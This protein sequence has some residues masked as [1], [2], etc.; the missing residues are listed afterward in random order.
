MKGVMQNEE[1]TFIGNRWNSMIRLMLALLLGAVGIWA[2]VL[3][4]LFLGV[5]FLIAASLAA[6]G[7]LTVLVSPRSRYLRL[8]AT[9]FEVGF[10]HAKD[11][12]EW[13]EVVGFRWSM[14]NRAQVIEIE[15]VPEYGLS[16]HGTRCIFDRYDAPLT[17][18]LEKLNEWRRRYGPRS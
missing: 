5:A 18:V 9:G 8:D 15:Y 11:C 14:H 10:R 12:V 3:D 16:G 7:S 13:S 1:I 17:E 2:L 4:H 6:S